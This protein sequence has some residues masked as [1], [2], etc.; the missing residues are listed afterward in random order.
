MAPIGDVLDYTAITQWFWKTI[1]TRIIPLV[2]LAVNEMA[3]A[4]DMSDMPNGM[5]MGEMD[6]SPMS[7]TFFVSSTTSLFSKAWTPTTSAEYAGTCI[8]LIVLA[9][10]MRFMLA[11]K[12]VLEKSIWNSAVGPGGEL[13]PDEEAGFQKENMPTQSPLMRVYGDI[14][15][16]W[17][18]WRFN[19]SL[20]RACFEL[21]LASVG[22]LL[23]VPIQWQGA[24][25]KLHGALV[26]NP[27]IECSQL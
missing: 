18:V 13:I 21:S 22:Y 1:A 19:T 20:G 7:M 15:K 10:V 24:T 12:P 8:F 27:K 5:D 2:P 23:Y 4:M 14:R 25:L 26:A 6:D 17:A 9:V 3:T 11:L 16:R